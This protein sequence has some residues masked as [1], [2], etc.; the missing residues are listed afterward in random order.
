MEVLELGKDILIK[1]IIQKI[2]EEFVE[3]RKKRIEDRFIR[4]LGMNLQEFYGGTCKGI[5]IEIY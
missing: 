4:P 2:K 1:N 3:I 5:L